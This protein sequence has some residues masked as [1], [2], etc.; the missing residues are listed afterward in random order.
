[1]PAECLW[2]VLWVT[3]YGATIARPCAAQYLPNVSGTPRLPVDI[4]Q[5]NLTPVAPQAYGSPGL[6]APLMGSPAFSAPA[7][8]S[9]AY[10]GP[11]APPAASLGTP[12][13]DPYS[14]GANPGAFAPAVQGVPPVSS[15][16]FPGWLPSANSSQSPGL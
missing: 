6:G 16:Q 1:M 3:L 10:T 8:T 15:P 5:T 2:A 13:F 4:P 14:T 12:L 7:Y 9:P 11:I